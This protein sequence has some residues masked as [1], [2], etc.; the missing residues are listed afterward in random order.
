MYQRAADSVIS[1]LPLLTLLWTF[2]ENKKKVII[3]NKR[4][5]WTRK[6]IRRSVLNYSKQHYTLLYS[7]LLNV[8]LKFFGFLGY[9]S[10]GQWVPN[11]NSA[12]IICIYI[13]RDTS[14]CITLHY[15]LL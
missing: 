9:D 14:Y 4:R 8:R 1:L 7:T 3:L 15:V 2:R 13:M 5:K 11:L 12:P 6:V 10:T